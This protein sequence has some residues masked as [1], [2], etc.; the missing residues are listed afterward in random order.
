[1]VKSV[2]MIL[3]VAAW[4]AATRTETRLVP[5]GRIRRSVNGAKDGSVVPIN[6]AEDRDPG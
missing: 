2:I 4:K 1:M 6:H 5:S 3:S